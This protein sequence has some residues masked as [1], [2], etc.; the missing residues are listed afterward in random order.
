MELIYENSARVGEA[1][2]K[3]TAARIEPYREYLNQM[4]SHDRYDAHEC[5]VN[6]PID[7]NLIGQVKDVKKKKAGKKLKYLVVI[8]IGGSSLGAKAVYDALYGGFDLIEPGRFPKIM[9][10]ETN[11]PL[12]LEKFCAFLKTVKTP[13]E[14]LLNA[15]SKSG[16]TTET[17]ANLEIIGAAF[18][19]QFGDAALHDRLVV[20]T[21]ENSR[22]WNL[23]KTKK[24]TLLPIPEAVGGRYSV[25]SPA[26]LFPLHAAGVDLDSFCEG[27]AVMRKNCIE[28]D[29]NQN[30]ALISAALL[31]LNAGAGKTINDNFFFAPQL[32]SL[33]KWYRQLMGESIGKEQDREGSIVHAGLTP[34]V[35]IGSTDLHSV[36]QLYLGGPQDKFTTFVWVRNV[37]DPMPLPDEL[38]T[39]NLVENL[40]NKSAQKIMEAILEGTKAAYSHKELPFM[41]NVLPEISAFTLG[42]YLQ[43]KMVE[44]MYLGRLFGVNTFDQPNVELYK[45][46]TRKILKAA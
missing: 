15:I 13:E 18:K 23:A 28:N 6:L 32:E 42:E 34:T 9:F 40:N 24:I 41:E 21:D 1:Q 46:E 44:M 19:E 7:Q 43:Y 45:K 37:P 2:L 36:G 8:G 17:V 5:S 26:G 20:T 30:P 25:F 10:L 29:L 4:L 33:G 3:E 38:F 22:L 14:I 27:A 31:Y 12:Y 11:D 35:S 39:D 16:T